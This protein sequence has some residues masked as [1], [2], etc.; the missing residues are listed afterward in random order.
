[1][2]DAKA[3]QDNGQQTT[4]TTNKPINRTSMAPQSQWRKGS[5][6]AC[7]QRATLFNGPR[8][9]QQMAV[10]GGK[11]RPCKVCAVKQYNA[12]IHE[13]VDNVDINSRIN[14]VVSSYLALRDTK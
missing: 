4:T 13:R 10:T 5:I 1:M 9:F 14:N 7:K 8:T 11:A 3:K 6:L 2:L 12:R